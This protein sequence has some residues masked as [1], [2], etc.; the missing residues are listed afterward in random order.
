MILKYYPHGRWPVLATVIVGMIVAGFLLWPRVSLLL[1]PARPIVNSLSQD[2]LWV[3][4]D[5]PT[6]T[7]DTLDVDRIRGIIGQRPL[8]VVVLGADNHAFDRPLDACTAVVDRIDDLTVMVIQ[9][10]ELGAGCQGDDV[11]ITDN[12]FGYDFVFWEMMDRQT[13]F[14]HGTTPGSPPGTSNREPA[15]SALPPGNG[16]WPRGSCWRSPAGCCCCSSGY[17]ARSWP[18]CGGGNAAAG[19]YQLLAGAALGGDPDQDDCRRSIE[20]ST[21]GLALLSRS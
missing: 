13:A 18:C 5:L 15:P 6:E 1:S 19:G 20:L 4:P 10:G 9:D 21:T 14:L 17:G 12:E 3:D 2:V 8:G 11:P 7:V 16:Y